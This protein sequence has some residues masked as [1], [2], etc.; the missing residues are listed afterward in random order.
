ML[1]TKPRVLI[2]YNYLFHYRIPIWNILAEKYELKVIYSYPAKEA[3]IKKCNFETEY[4]PVKSISKLLYHEKKISKI[5]EKYDVVL[6]DGQVTFIDYSWLALR[7]RNY[8]LIYWCIGAPASYGRHYGE[9]GKGYFL[10]NDFFHRKADAMVFYSDVPIESHVSR[11]YKRNSLFVANNTVQV[12]RIDVDWENKKNLL[13]IGTLY[14]EKGRQLLLDAYKKATT[15]KENILP[16]TIVGGGKQYDEVC[17]WVNDNNLNEKIV[18]TG[19]VYDQSEKAKIFAKSIACISPLQAGLSVLESMGYGVPF[20]T[21]SDAITGGEA[22][23]ISDRETGLRLDD[24][25]VLSRVICDISENPEIYIEMGKKAYS[26]YWSC[27]RPE[28]MARGLEDAIEYVKSL[29]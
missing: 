16:L 4:I 26:H 22:F 20:I 21:S 5:A 29:K 11:G 3:E 10:V 27:R 14:L 28:D 9:A 7:K 1:M 12:E 24:I 8:K 25:S 15:E 6:S 18:L 23:N 17:K 13:F 19:P 2:L